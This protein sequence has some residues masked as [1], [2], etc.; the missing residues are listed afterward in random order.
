MV[1]IRAADG[2]GEMVV[3]PLEV[4]PLRS[5]TTEGVEIIHFD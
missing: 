2:G 5:I 4:T 1:D 3:R